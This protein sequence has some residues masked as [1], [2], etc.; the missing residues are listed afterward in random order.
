MAKPAGPLC[1]LD[2]RYC[3]YLE[4]EA[5]F[6]AHQPLRMT[7]E[8]LERFIVQYLG[9]QAGPEVAFTWQGRRT[10]PGRFGLFQKG[11]GATAP[12]RRGTPRHQRPANQRTLLDDDWG[13]FLKTP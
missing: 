11:G 9:Q 7:P 4:K 2:C 6:P 3:F 12:S 13:R 1:N 8:V 10:H 5:L